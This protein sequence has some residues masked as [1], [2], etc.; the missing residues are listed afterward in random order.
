MNKAEKYIKKVDDFC[1]PESYG[2]G[3][4]VLGT[5]IEGITTKFRLNNGEIIALKGTILDRNDED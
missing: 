3:L 1:D 5:G 2:E 4:T